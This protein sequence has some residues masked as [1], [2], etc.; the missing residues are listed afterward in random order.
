MSSTGLKHL[1][2]FKA[3]VEYLNGLD[4]NYEHVK[5][6]VILNRAPTHSHPLP[7]TPTH[8]HP[9]PPTPTRSHPLPLTPTHSHSL[10]PTPIHSH[11]SSTY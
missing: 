4:D 8:S 6:W 3:F 2:D 7:L 5:E 9:L 1:N 10:P 11:P